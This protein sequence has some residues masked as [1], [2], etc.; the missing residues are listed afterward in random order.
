MNDLGKHVMS[1]A[2]RVQ[3]APFEIE[4]IREHFRRIGNP[5]A[6]ANVSNE[7]MQAL[8]TFVP[9]MPVNSDMQFSPSF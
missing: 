9:E 2:N 7:F 1:G 6:G 8:R 3:D 4:H 5:D